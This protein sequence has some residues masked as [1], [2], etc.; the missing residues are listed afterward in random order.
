MRLAVRVS[1]VSKRYALALFKEGKEKN[2]LDTLQE[3]LEQIAKIHE[4]TPEFERMIS[5][6]VIPERVK[7]ET[8]AAIFEDRLDPITFHF[9]QLLISTGREELLMDVINF[10][11]QILDDH[12]GIVRGQVSSVV[13]FTD[14]Q[15]E[16]LKRKLD[17]VIGKNVILTQVRDESLLGGFVVKIN[18]SV[19]D[20]SLRNQLNR[21]GEYLMGTQ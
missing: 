17:K 7:E 8:F 16:D 14:G 20:S 13:P 10:F 5:S 4:E 2:K 18:D 15:M 12:N 19:I 9:V 6:P 3:D 21:M 1:R 11:N